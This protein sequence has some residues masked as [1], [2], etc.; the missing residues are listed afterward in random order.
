MLCAQ[1]QQGHVLGRCPAAHLGNRA[2]N[3]PYRIMVNHNRTS[4]DDRVTQLQGTVAQLQQ[5]L[6]RMQAERE[7]ASRRR[8]RR[9]LM[10]AM[11]VS[12]VLHMGL[13]VY[14][15]MM[16]RAGGAEG[17]S[18]A[19]AIE[20]ASINEQ[21][22]TSHESLDTEQWLQADSLNLAD[23]AM[24]EPSLA[25]EAAD[26][27]IELSHHAAA[28]LESL[29]SSGGGIG[30]GDGLAGGGA[31]ASYFGI[32][33][34]GT[35]FAFIVDR[36]GSMN[37]YNR[38]PIAI[39]ELARAIQGLPDYSYF[40]IQF[41]SSAVVQPPM[42]SGW[43]QARRGN[44]IPVLRWLETVDPS[45]GTLPREAMQNA[46]AMDVRPDVIYF[47]TDGIISPS[48][49]R[50]EEVAQWNST[51]KRVVVNTIAFGDEGSEEMLRQIANESGGA[52]RYVPD[53]APTP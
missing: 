6:R 1:Q 2:A 50:A 30:E 12:I 41:F 49:L 8:R 35:R 28:T 4:T 45:G 9:L 7:F 26:S 10:I 14:L 21:S 36:S 39:N 37:A 25:L 33:A 24:D 13:L 46:F 47:M 53:G 34:T 44:V 40:H 32:T 11:G 52:Y 5:V 38:W 18:V 27:T 19:V 31:G 17:G 29:S 3:F 48:A 42:Q 23:V 22:L 15:S 20:F 51:G 16:Q 43:I